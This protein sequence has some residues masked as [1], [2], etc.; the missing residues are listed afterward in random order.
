[1]DYP[2]VTTGV[3]A[4]NTT[5]EAA[6]YSVYPQFTFTAKEM[7]GNVSANTMTTGTF[8]IT[9]RETGVDSALAISWAITQTGIKNNNTT[10]VVITSGTDKIT[11]K[12][13]NSD[14]VGSA[15]FRWC[16][17]LGSTAPPVNVH[18]FMDHHL[19]VFPPTAVAY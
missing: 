16:G 4:N 3:A 11:E 8:T 14:L 5:D 9:L 18:P 17:F 7:I 12:A 2:S 6:F 15:T 19:E 13:H 10:Q 1:L